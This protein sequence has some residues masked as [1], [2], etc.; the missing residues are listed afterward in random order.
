MCELMAMSS[1]TESDITLSLSELSLRGGETDIH[2]DGWGVAY[3]QGYDVALFKEPAAAAYSTLMQYVQKLEV[4]SH[5]V[6]AHIR[7]ANVGMNALSNTHPFTR[8]MA[9]RQHV[10]AHNGQLPEIIGNKGFPLGRFTPIGNTDSE[11]AF[12]VLLNQLEAL[13][14][15]Q[16]DPTMRSRLDIVAKFSEHLRR[17]GPANFIYSDGDYLFVHADQRVQKDGIRRPP[18][19]YGLCRQCTQFED[20]SRMDGMKTNSKDKQVVM[21]ASV[22]LSEEGWM[23]LDRG[24]IVVIK[25]GNIMMSTHMERTL[26][27]EHHH[28]LQ[29]STAG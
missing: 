12:C 7:Q 14:E 27:H 8:E 1:L 18:G 5:T 25:E 20:L 17:H 23:P 24:E 22:P 19:L 15:N 9:G 6:I 26:P 16:E 2:K 4:R 13:W 29:P 10:F 3:Y 28:H 11:Y 21:I